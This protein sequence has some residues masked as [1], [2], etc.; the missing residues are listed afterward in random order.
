MADDLN[1]NG[2]IEVYTGPRGFSVTG[3]T[4]DGVNVRFTTDEPRTLNPVPL[5]RGRPGAKGDKGD[6][7]QASIRVDETVGYRVFL[8]EVATPGEQMVYGDTGFRTLAGG[9]LRR[10]G[11][12]VETT[13]TDLASLP[14]GF[15]P[16][17]TGT[18]GPV[19]TTTDDWP[20]SLPGTKLTDP[21]KLRGLEG[22]DAATA[23]GYPGTPDQWLEDRYRVLQDPAGASLG[24]VYTRTETGAGWADLPTI[25]PEPW[26]N[27]TLDR[28]WTTSSH[29]GNLAQTRTNNGRVD[30]YGGLSYVGPTVEAGM[31]SWEGVRIGVLAPQ[32]APVFNMELVV[33]TYEGA[34]GAGR[35]VPARLHVS[36]QG[37]MQLMCFS[38]NGEAQTLTI[39]AGV[40]FV[41]ITG[42]GYA[43]RKQ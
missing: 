27:I 5:P 30:F 43:T 11:N 4:G 13:V 20:A 33:I 21:V 25:G 17:R 23:N 40:T 26:R 10:T 42:L 14:A 32:D 34:S 28:T 38:D 22:Y 2:D 15:K 31:W 41:G 36:D 35:P 8:W 39:K 3:A 9:V 24:Q 1:L 18:T 6:P 16:G 12:T 7:G 29:L 37:V 19:F